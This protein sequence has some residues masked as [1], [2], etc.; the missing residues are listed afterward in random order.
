MNKHDLLAEADRLETEAE[1]AI[2]AAEKEAY[3][4]GR[5]SMGSR[6]IS[7]PEADWLRTRASDLRREADDDIEP[8]FDA[9]AAAIPSP[10][11]APSPPA[12]PFAAPAVLLSPEIQAMIDNLIHKPSASAP[13]APAAPALPLA[14]ELMAWEAHEAEVA[15]AA[16]RISTGEGYE[17]FA[18]AEAAERAK[19]RAADEQE[20]AQYET[21]EAVAQRISEA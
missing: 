19:Q 12:L 18:R 15:A 20:N 6:L 14:R 16:Q 8:S 17:A 10:A 11:A 3:L 1:A 7:C 9:P 2:L 21:A 13:A 4:N 5:L